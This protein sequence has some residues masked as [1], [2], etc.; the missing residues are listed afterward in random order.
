[1]PEKD[2]AHQRNNNELFEQLVTEV[3]HCA[4]DQ[5]AAVVG[6]D[7][8]HARWQAVCQLFEFALDRCNRLASIL[9]AAQNH[10]AADGLP[11]AVE[12]ANATAHFRTQLDRSDI[13]QGHGY[14]THT[15]LERDRPKVI[16][17]L[18]VTR[19]AHD[20][21]G[22]SHFQHRTTGFLVGLAN[23]LGY[24]RLSDTESRQF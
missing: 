8:F 12:F 24:L 19:S 23:R 21:L 17:R 5:L 2:P 20:E 6:G 18:Q 14:S 16:E 9:A 1:M 11:F 7:G 3:F 13:A 10:H 15:E 4:V 22:L